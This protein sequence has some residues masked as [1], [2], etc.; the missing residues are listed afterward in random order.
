MSQGV[1]QA[2]GQYVNAQE[3]TLQSAVVWTIWNVGCS[4]AIYARF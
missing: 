3:L 4:V 2:T 1:L